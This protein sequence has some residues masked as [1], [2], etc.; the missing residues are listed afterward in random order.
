[1]RRP[2]RVLALQLYERGV[3][4]VALIGRTISNEQR[5]L[6]RQFGRVFVMLD[7]D[8]PGR[9]STPPVVAKVAEVT[10]AH[11]CY[12][13]EGVQPSTMTDEQLDKVLSET[14]Q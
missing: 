13:P 1:M 8:Q 3:P 5:E 12:L 11:A 10:W 14:R 9:E 6:L 2:D 4:C 7:G